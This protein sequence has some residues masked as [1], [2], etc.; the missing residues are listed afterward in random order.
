LDIGP[1]T[2]GSSG[3]SG[4]PEKPWTEGKEFYIEGTI[5]PMA[6]RNFEERGWKFEE[7]FSERL[8]K[9]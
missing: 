1:G 7:R 4:P 2:K 3:F 8:L 6:R 9:K 5:E